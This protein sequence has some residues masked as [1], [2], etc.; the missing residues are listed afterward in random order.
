MVVNKIVL[1]DFDGVLADTLDDML[2]FAERVCANLGFPRTPTQRDLNALDRMAF[3]ELGRQLELPQDKIQDFVRGSLE[4]FSQCETLKIFEGMDDVIVRLSATSKIG[5]VTGNTSGVVK[6]FLDHY[7]LAK[8]VNLVLGV[9][10]PGSRP[11]KIRQ[12]VK[13]IGGLLGGTA[14]MVGDAVSDI[15]A[16][17]EA[18]VV[19]VAVGWGHQNWEKLAQAQP[20]YLVRSPKELLTVLDT[21]HHCQG[22]NL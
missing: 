21:C 2:L 14:Y 3:E 20:D 5:V 12:A 16:A 13:Q 17:Q 7:G 1:F 8:Y 10:V 11:E 15:R 4:M 18:S 22:G 6:R 9:D 19:S